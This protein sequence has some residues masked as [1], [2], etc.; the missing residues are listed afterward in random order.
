MRH[1][2]DT[3]ASDTMS[4]LL[5]MSSAIYMVTHAVNQEQIQ[6]QLGHADQPT[7][8]PAWP[9]VPLTTLVKAS[10]LR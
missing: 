7:V 8:E 1:G 5:C 3:D 10:N 2:D 4:D 9:G 6:S